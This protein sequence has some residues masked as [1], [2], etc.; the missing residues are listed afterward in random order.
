[1]AKWPFKKVS[2]FTAEL[3]EDKRRD[4]QSPQNQN[5]NSVALSG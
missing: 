2:N 1:M 4:S 5:E 3:A